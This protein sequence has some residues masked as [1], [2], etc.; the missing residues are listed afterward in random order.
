MEKTKIDL[1]DEVQKIIASLEKNGHA[2]Y[3]VGG[4]V[5]DKIMGKTPHDWDITTSASPEETEKIFFKNKLVLNGMK[6]GT[7]GVVEDGEVYEV[8]TFRT[9][10]AYSDN[11]H[12]DSVTFVNNIEDDLARRD[13]TVNSVAYSPKTGLVD[14]FGGKEDIEKKIIRCVGQAGR[15]FDEDALRIMR[16]VRFSSTLGFEIEEKTS[17]KIHEK[18]SLLK[19]VSTERIRDELEKLL[20]GKNVFDVLKNYSDVIFSV[21]P[22][23]SYSDGW[24]TV[25]KGVEASENEIG[26][27]LALI[28]Q[29]LSKDDT[30]A[31]LKRLKFDNKTTDEVSKLVE[32]CA[33]KTYEKTDELPFLINRFGYD[34]LRNLV[35]VS[36]AK[37]I[38][39]NGENYKEL[40]LCDE[41]L[42]KLDECEEKNI[43]VFVSQ[44]DVDGND[45]KQLGFEG[46]SIG[47]TLNECLKKVMRNELE[48]DRDTLIEYVK[49]L[50]NH[51]TDL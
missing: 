46:K 47:T 29:N 50:K 33:G 48:N 8:T 4:C 1:P 16:A 7:V 14:P 31:V 35:K 51:K 43:C 23:L 11:R 13:F 30:L 49:S 39:Q 27:R 24:E 42:K 9:E 44:L 34:F 18:K 36:K 3:V 28:M 25:C 19:N 45:L 26:I 32:H 40:F 10:G 5:R 21:I 12:P 6:H 2:A 17:R 15:R 20:G 22:E 37:I 38:A 41:F